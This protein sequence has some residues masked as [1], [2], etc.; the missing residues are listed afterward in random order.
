MSG[1]SELKQRLR[2]DLTAAIKGRD[3]LT[4]STLRM[5]LAAIQNAEMAGATPRDL[6]DDDVQGVLGTEVKRRKEAADAFR[7]AGREEQAA[8]EE[9]EAVILRSYLPQQLS[10]EALSA[11]V[12]DAIAETGATDPKAMGQ[13]MKAVM[14]RVQGRADGKEVSAEVR[15]QLAG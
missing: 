4:S 5:A 10:T 6:T 1:V 13:V 15:R 7:G 8:K 11:A 14:A 9:S 12:A 3:P 2:T